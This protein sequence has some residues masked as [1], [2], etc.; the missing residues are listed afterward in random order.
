MS[1][2]IKSAF[3]MVAWLQ[4]KRKA[5]GGRRVKYL[6]RDCSGVVAGRTCR[7]RCPMNPGQHLQPPS[8]KAC[9]FKAMC[10]T[11]VYMY[12]D[13]TRDSM[14]PVVEYVQTCCI[15]QENQRWDTSITCWPLTPDVSIAR[16]FS[17]A[18]SV[19]PHG[20]MRPGIPYDC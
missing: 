6:S 15:C 18:L 17:P 9:I 1:K 2:R 16:S 19:L 20:I 14:T 13:E 12:T 4:L 7:F 10:N 11:I 3:T 8:K 5:M